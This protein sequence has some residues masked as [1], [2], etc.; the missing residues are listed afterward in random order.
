M[1]LTQSLDEF[2]KWRVTKYLDGFMSISEQ[3]YLVINR[4]SD[5]DVATGFEVDWQQNM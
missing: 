1:Q 4:M 2:E 3:D 5:Q